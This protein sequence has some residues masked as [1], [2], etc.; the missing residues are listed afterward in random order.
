M[1]IIYCINSIRGLGGI[2]RVTLVKANALAEVAGNQVYLIVTDNWPYHKLIHEISDKITLIHL[3]INYY[4]DD[5]KSKFQSLIS[6]V[7]IFKH[8]KLLQ[9]TIN[10]IKPDVII[11]VGQ[12]EKYILPFLHT[13]AIKIREIHFNSN[14]REFTYQTKWI[15][16][17][18]QFLDFHINTH[19]YDKVILL[20]E[21]DKNV[22]FAHNK[23]FT[24][25]HNPLTTGRL[26]HYEKRQNK[27]VIAVGRLSPQKNFTSLI[28][29]WALI[30]TQI[31]DWHLNI[32]GE[33]PER[34]KLQNEIYQLHLKDSVTLKGFSSE[35]NKELKESSISIISSLYEGFG[36]VILEA[37]A[38]GLPVISYRFPY[39]PQDIIDHGKNGFLVPNQ[40]EQALA[41]RIL[42]LV[43][44]EELRNRMG[45][46][47][48]K[49]TYDFDISLIVQ[50]WMT[51]FYN[52][53]QQKRRK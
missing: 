25:I 32:V 14:Y 20:T 40:D 47:A 46:A 27:N 37:M 7:K 10:Q 34:E 39:G 31:P 1:K 24:A 38:M 29:A 51:L 21:E 4:A 23:K 5:Y 13:K 48:L 49:R 17:L 8:W 53:T 41:A 9:K 18:L 52:E 3:P 30:A 43:Q 45:Q 22:N 16:K 33:G 15:G 26:E 6:N 50:K 12:S 36:L 11:S 44:N 42:E 19:G 35:V 2:Q 28:R